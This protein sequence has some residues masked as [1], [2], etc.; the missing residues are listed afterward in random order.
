MQQHIPDELGS[1]IAEIA[2]SM[3]VGVED[4]VRVALEDWIARMRRAQGRKPDQPIMDDM[5]SA[6]V[7]L[8]RS[9]S[10]PVNVQQGTPHMP[11]GVGLG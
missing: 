6:P 2:A 5:M 8:P 1:E 9:A 11:D 4:A 7:D 10:R 3:N